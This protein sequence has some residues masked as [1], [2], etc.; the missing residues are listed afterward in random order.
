MLCDNLT[1]YQNSNE[2]NT[3]EAQFTRLVCHTRLKILPFTHDTT[4]P[5]LFQRSYEASELAM[6]LQ[7][8]N[9]A[10]EYQD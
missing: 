4:D 9:V 2:T 8:Q 10:A 5:S 1:R 3:H 6:N 7:T